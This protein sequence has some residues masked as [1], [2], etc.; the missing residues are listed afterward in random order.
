MCN[1]SA[2]DFKI[3]RS[4]YPDPGT[5]LDDC[6]SRAEENDFKTSRGTSCV[7]LTMICNPSQP[8]AIVLRVSNDLVMFHRCCSFPNKPFL[9][10]SGEQPY[11]VRQGLALFSVNYVSEPGYFPTMHSSEPQSSFPV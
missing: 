8:A 3:E 4:C 6:I 7:L 9:R 1:I 2:L 11:W 10:K 5:F